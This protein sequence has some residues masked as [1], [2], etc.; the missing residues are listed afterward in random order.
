M[1]LQYLGGN[2]IKITAKKTSIVIDDNLAKLGLKPVASAKDI[3]LSTGVGEPASE[4]RFIIDHPGEYEVSDVSIQGI[5]VR[6]HM[7]EAKQHSTTMY[8][9]LLDG[10]RIAVTGHIHPDLTDVE[11]EALGTV[12]ILVLPVGGNGY[13]LDGI[14]AQKVVK[15]IEPKILVPTHYDDTDITYE[16]PQTPLD[17]AIKGLAMEPT[18]TVDSLKLKPADIGEGS[19]R[20]IIVNRK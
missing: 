1:E 13:T 11:L 9:I 16:V 7:D 2:C 19:T 18:D 3:V 17:D 14:G 20:L 4:A 6:S 12:D 8:R 10:I 15:E 5:A